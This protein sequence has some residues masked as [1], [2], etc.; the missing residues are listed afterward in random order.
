[1]AQLTYTPSK[2]QLTTVVGNGARIYRTQSLFLETIKPEDTALPVFTLEDT[3]NL[4]LGLPS[5]PRLYLEARDPTEYLPA[6]TILGSMAHWQKL[7]GAAWFK[8]YIEEMRLELS[9][10]IKYEAIKQLEWESKNSSSSAVR[11]SAQKFL[12][13]VGSELMNQPVDKISARRGRPSQEELNGV[14]K[15]LTDEER[16]LMEDHQ[17]VL[18]VLQ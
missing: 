1:M 6:K 15:N 14:L 2:Q 11:V 16:R 9:K 13:T 4:E 12:V 17:R 3:D 8:S 10:L 5:F 7:T 18:N